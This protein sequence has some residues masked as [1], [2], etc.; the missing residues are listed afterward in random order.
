MSTSCIAQLDLTYAK[1]T[2]LTISESLSLVD[3]NSWINRGIHSELKRPEG[4]YEPQSS[5]L[6]RVTVAG[7]TSF[8]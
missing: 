4:I 6:E 7:P 3:G 1:A 5:I 8:S 2:G